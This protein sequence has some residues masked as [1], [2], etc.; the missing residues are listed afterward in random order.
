M[1]ATPQVVAGASSTRSEKDV[2][3]ERQIRHLKL[4]AQ[5]EGVSPRLQQDLIASTESAFAMADFL[6][7]IGG[8]MA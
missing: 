6:S 3:R 2:R 5:R 4:V 7:A 1:N 8:R